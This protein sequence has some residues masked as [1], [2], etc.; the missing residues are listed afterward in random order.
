VGVF[1]F[2]L[3]SFQVSASTQ[4]KSTATYMSAFE[5]FFEA[6]FFMASALNFV[7]LKSFVFVSAALGHGE[8]QCAYTGIAYTETTSQ[9]SN[10]LALEVSDL[11]VL[12]FH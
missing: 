4:I 8:L 7:V 3:S 9:I 11:R 2:E 1:Y 6:C 12:F 10:N 5:T